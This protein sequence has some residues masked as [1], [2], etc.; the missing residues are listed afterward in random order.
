MLGGKVDATLGAFW[1]YEGVD[2]Q[3]RGRDPQIQRIEQLGV[4]TYSELVFV[5]RRRD[6]DQDF[7]ARVRRFMQATARGHALLRDDPAT[8][9]DALLEADPGLDRGLQAASVEATLP[10]FFPEDPDQPFGWQDE[11]E[12]QRYADWMFDNRLIKQRQNVEQVLTNEFL[13]GQG[14]DPRGALEQD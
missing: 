10:V 12:W 14:L 13:A 6:L 5:V 8:G 4:P 1:N 2:L 7:G 3:R 9:V 11:A